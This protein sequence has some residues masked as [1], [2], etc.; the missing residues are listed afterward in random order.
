MSE[1]CE[2]PPSLFQ[3]HSLDLTPCARTPWAFCG[4]DSTKRRCLCHE[5]EIQYTSQQKAVR[6]KTTFT[7]A[8][9]V[10][11]ESTGFCVHRGCHGYWAWL[12]AARQGFEDSKWAEA[13]LGSQ[14]RPQW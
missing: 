8:L 10:L 5:G 3:F 2:N 6:T 14:Q 13:L 1:G 12:S 4:K 7:S 11:R 9:E